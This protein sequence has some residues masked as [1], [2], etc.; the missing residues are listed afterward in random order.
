MDLLARIPMHDWIA[1]DSSWRVSIRLRLARIAERVV[2][3]GPWDVVIVDECRSSVRLGRGP[4]VNQ[5]KATRSLR[6]L[7]ESLAADGRLILLSGT[8]HQGSSSIDSQTLCDCYRMTAKIL[9]GAMGRVI[10]RTK[11]RGSRLARQSRS[12]PGATYGPPGLHLWAV[13]FTSGTKR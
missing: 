10:Y 5:I 6:L 7:S 4:V 8:P 1:I 13:S 2:K 9:S 12:F 11:E 3:S